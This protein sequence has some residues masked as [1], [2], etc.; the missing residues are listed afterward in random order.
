MASTALNAGP[1]GSWRSPGR[2]GKAP[3][4]DTLSVVRVH[5]GGGCTVGGGRGCVHSDGGAG[6]WSTSGRR[7]Q[8][9][10]CQECVSPA[11]TPGLSGGTGGQSFFS[12]NEPDLQ[13]DSQHPC[14]PAGDDNDGSPL[15]QGRRRPLPALSTCTGESLAKE[16]TDSSIPRL[17]AHSLI[18]SLPCL[19]PHLHPDL[20]QAPLPTREAGGGRGAGQV[21]G[22]GFP[23]GTI[24]LYPQRLSVSS[25]L[26]T[27]RPGPPF[28]C[29]LLFQNLP[30]QRKG[31]AEGQ[32]VVLK[33]TRRGVTQQQDLEG[34]RSA[35]GKKGRNDQEPGVGSPFGISKLTGESA[36]Q[37]TFREETQ[38]QSKNALIKPRT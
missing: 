2:V 30:L 4:A 3:P 17:P 33:T 1:R 5:S 10:H 19:L 14:G 38:A 37:A 35:S 11:A 31:Q 16:K 18:P 7:P 15:F 6:R 21:F 12:R 26:D 13:Q 22:D 36:G 28:S 9:V 8:A 20:V 23:D 27:S 32:R 34:C 24:S 29:V 25:C